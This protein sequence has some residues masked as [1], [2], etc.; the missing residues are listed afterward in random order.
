MDGV[1]G[2]KHHHAEAGRPPELTV[3]AEHAILGGL[4]EVDRIDHQTVGAAS[5]GMFGQSTSDPRAVTD[6]GEH[7]DTVGRSFGAH[8]NA[9]AV[10]IEIERE[11]LADASADDDC[12]GT[13]PA[14]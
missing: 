7:R 9:L 13:A 11:V 3:V 1:F 2:A 12:V 4:D 6:T 8:P 5:F 10:F 14:E